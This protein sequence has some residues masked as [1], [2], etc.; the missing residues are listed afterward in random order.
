MRINEAQSLALLRTH[1]AY[2]TEACDG[3]G[4]I[5]GAV[6]YSRQGE[7]G[8]WCSQLC[9]DGVERKAGV[10]YGC[11]TPLNGKR[12]D[13]LYCSRTC[14][15]RKVRRIQESANSV[16]THVADKG[17]TGA[18]SRVGYPD[19]KKPAITAPMSLGAPSTRILVSFQTRTWPPLCTGCR[20]SLARTRNEN[21]RR[22]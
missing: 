15:M 11:G 16:N 18:I 19:T 4:K 14:R 2:V 10:C 8:E 22:I 5:L 17:L 3:C 12:N 20:L 9:R 6:R 13:A 21:D 7:K 1:G